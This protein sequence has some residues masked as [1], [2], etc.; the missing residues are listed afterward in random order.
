MINQ[1]SREFY[2]SVHYWL[3]KKYGVASRCTNKKCLKISNN[4]SWAK[5]RNC[6]YDYKRSNFIEL[7]RSCHSRYDLTEETRKKLHLA[8]VGKVMSEEDK[9]RRSEKTKGIER[10][11]IV[12]DKIRKTQLKKSGSTIF[13]KG[14]KHYLIE[15]A[16]MHNIKDVTLRYRIRKMGLSV[17]EALNKRIYARTTAIS[18]INS[19]LPKEDKNI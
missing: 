9:R 7:C 6:E 8:N 10:P 2:S 13:Y 1:V 14:K 5:K 16:N 12:K 15:L 18:I 19:K 17:E 11:E 4:F 3:K